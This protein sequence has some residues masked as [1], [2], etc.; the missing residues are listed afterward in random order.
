MIWIVYESGSRCGLSAQMF[1]TQ[2]IKLTKSTDVMYCIDIDETFKESSR[3]MFN[4]PIKKFGE[5]EYEFVKDFGQ[6]YAIFPADELTRQKAGNR[7]IEKSWF[8]SVKPEYYDK[9]YV[10]KHLDIAGLNV[11]KTFNCT[12]VF[13]RPNIFSAGSKGVYRLDN[14][15]VSEFIDIDKEYVVDCFVNPAESTPI[16]IARE[17]KLHYGYD[18]YIRIVEDE[19]VINFAKKVISN[20]PIGMFIGP[21]HMQLMRDRKGNLY[22]IE[23]SKRISGTSLV[24][25]NVGYNPFMLLSGM[26]CDIK[27]SDEM[28]EWHIYEELYGKAIDLCNTKK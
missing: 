8:N 9:R 3:N 1:F 28:K 26:K 5:D 22:Y 7:V 2:Y 12:D 11:P 20:A 27:I 18:K 4:A 25:M 17:V 14:V 15:C 6:P 16:I 23:G 19:D 10:N 21:C 24:L 13:L